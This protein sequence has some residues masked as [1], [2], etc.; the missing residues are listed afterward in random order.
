MQSIMKM[1]IW[2]YFVCGLYMTLP[3]GRDILYPSTMALR[4]KNG[5]DTRTKGIVTPSYD[6]GGMLPMAR[7]THPLDPQP[8]RHSMLVPTV[9]AP[10]V[11]R[12]SLGEYW[13]CDWFRGNFSLTQ[14][15]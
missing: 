1:E 12:C 10:P 6:P 7:E 4:D 3:S 14:G 11:T 5:T 9:C 13:S 15:L 2:A 8:H